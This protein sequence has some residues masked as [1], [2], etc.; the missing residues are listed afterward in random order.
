MWKGVHRMMPNPEIDRS[1]Q[2]RHSWVFALIYF[3]SEWV[4]SKC[5]SNC[6]AQGLVARSAKSNSD[7][8]RCECIPMPNPSLQRDALPESRL[9]APELVR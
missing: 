5:N 9:L 3:S 7:L 8:Y 2:E 4:A 6:T 1:A